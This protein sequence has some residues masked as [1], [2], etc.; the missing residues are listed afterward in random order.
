MYF[1]LQ[2]L[3]ITTVGVF[4]TLFLTYCLL[5]WRSRAGNKKIAP[6]AAAA[7][8]II[9]HLHLL[10][11][12]SHQLPHI[13]LGNMADKYG[14][15]FTIRIGLHRALVVSSWEMAKECSTANDQV[16]SS[17]PELLASKHLGYNYAIFGFSP[18]G[19]YW[20]EM[21]KIISLELLS[22][23]RLELLKD[24]RA[25]EVVTSIKE[26]YKLWAEKKK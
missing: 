8:P 9:G 16:S 12:G 25:S 24:V 15:V 6:E 19:S 2:Y 17:R 10:A 14:P 11:G 23:S 1:L 20:R 13:T 21:R 3:N 22:N 4:A 7:W 26:L 5:L 18:Y